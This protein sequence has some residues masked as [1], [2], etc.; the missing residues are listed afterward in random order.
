[1]CVCV[2]VIQHDRR[3]EDHANKNI[4]ADRALKRM[5]PNKTLR[6]GQRA[7]HLSET[8]PTANRGAA[9]PPRPHVDYQYGARG[10]EIRQAALENAHG[11]VY[12]GRPRLQGRERREIDWGGDDEATEGLISHKT[13][14]REEKKERDYHDKTPFY[15]KFLFAGVPRPPHS[16]V[17]VR[18]IHTPGLYPPPLLDCSSAA[19]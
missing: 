9:A 6:G 5:A 11:H 7:S 15:M 8:A 4:M 14:P 12:H 16:N 17:L 18:S 2:C 3:M 1:M 13:N 19:P 10:R